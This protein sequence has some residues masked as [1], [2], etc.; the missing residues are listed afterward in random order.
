MHVLRELIPDLTVFDGRDWL[1]HKEV[2]LANKEVF[3]GLGKKIADLDIFVECFP[4]V[5]FKTQ[6]TP[7]DIIAPAFQT[8]YHI[9]PTAYGLYHA[10]EGY[11]VGKGMVYLF[12]FPL[13]RS[14]CFDRLFTNFVRYLSKRS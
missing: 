5:V 4:H 6:T 2:V 13:T 12:T 9:E 8:G 14:A 1:Y 10:I 7:D 3:A 11:K